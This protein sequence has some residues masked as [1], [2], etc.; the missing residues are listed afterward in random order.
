MG[1]TLRENGN[2][3]KGVRVGQQ[4]LQLQRGCAQWLLGKEVRPLITKAETACAPVSN[5]EAL[6]YSAERVLMELPRSCRL[7]E[8]S[9]DQPSSPVL[10]QYYSLI[11]LKH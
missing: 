2:G 11:F 6:G 1:A 10:P 8:I 3:T 7:R 4:Q 9:P 5:K